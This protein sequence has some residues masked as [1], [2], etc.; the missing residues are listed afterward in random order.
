M[1]REFSFFGIRL[2]PRPQEF[3][4]IA[5]IQDIYPDDGDEERIE[6]GENCRRNER[7]QKHR[8]NILSEGSRKSNKETVDSD[9]KKTVDAEK[10]MITIKEED[11]RFTSQRENAFK[12]IDR[13]NALYDQKENMPNTMKPDNETV[14]SKIRHNRIESVKQFLDSNFDIQATDSNGNTMIHLCAQNNLKK[15]ASVLLKYGC[16]KNERNFKGLTPLDYC[17]MYQHEALGE[18]MKGKGCESTTR[19]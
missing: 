10:M 14:F 11:D 4:D 1:N 16:P 9:C 19:K 12:P 18:W 17:Y 3:L 6:K 15:M 2:S 5:E 7:K 13:E 8:N